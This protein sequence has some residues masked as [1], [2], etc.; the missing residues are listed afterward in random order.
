MALMRR[1]K[2]ILLKVAEHLVVDYVGDEFQL[3]GYF[4]FEGYY[5][6]H[7]IKKLFVQLLLHHPPSDATCRKLTTH[8]S[9]Q[10]LNRL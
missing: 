7:F 2:K 10:G 3:N 8:T 4:Y 9:L 6:F 5:R 1:T